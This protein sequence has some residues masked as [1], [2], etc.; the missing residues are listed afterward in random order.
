[1]LLRIANVRTLARVAHIAKVDGGP[2]AIA[3]TPR[4]EPTKKAVAEAGLTPRNGR[5]ILEEAIVEPADRLARVEKV[6]Q[7][8]AGGRKRS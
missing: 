1:M 8:L 4:V 6:L 2:T 5:L 3:F 7:Q